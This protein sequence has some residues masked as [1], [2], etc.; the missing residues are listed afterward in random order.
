[1]TNP[2][3]PAI[4]VQ[5]ATFGYKKDKPVFQDVDI[6]LLPGDILSILGPNGAGKTTLLNCILNMFPLQQGS[7]HI[8]GKQPREYSIEQFA[9]EVAYVPQIQSSSLQYTVRDYVVMGRAPHLGL[10][11]T[12]GSE[13]YTK[14][15]NV[16]AQMNCSHLSSKSFGNLSGGERQQVQIAR[17]LVQESKII[18]MDEPTNHLDYGNQLRI[19]KIIVALAEQ[20]YTIILTTHMPDHAILLDGYTGILQPGGTMIVGHTKDVIREQSL[21]ELYDTDLHM[22]YIEKLGRSACIAGNIR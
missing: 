14:A 4:F 16:I 17:A 11:Q 6:S 22:I 18:L 12:P 10:M 21:T 1:M 20:G 13:D 5:Q 7:I 3:L 9:L 15:D 2:E 19:L 8:N